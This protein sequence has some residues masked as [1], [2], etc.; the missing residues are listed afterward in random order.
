MFYMIALKGPCVGAERLSRAPTF[1]SGRGRDG[2]GVTGGEG[3]GA[4]HSSS[5]LYFNICKCEGAGYFHK[6][7]GTI[8][9]RVRGDKKRYLAVFE[10]TLT[11]TLTVTRKQLS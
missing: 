6:D 9:S 3:L 11:L 1:V 8:S 2:D 10:A 4:S 5:R 7:L